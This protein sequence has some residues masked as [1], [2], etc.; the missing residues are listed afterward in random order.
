MILLAVVFT[1][2]YGVGELSV[3]FLR[4]F[5]AELLKRRDLWRKNSELREEQRRGIEKISAEIE[6]K[7]ALLEK[8]GEEYGEKKKAHELLTRAL[9]VPD[10]ETLSDYHP[11][12][13]GV[14]YFDRT[15]FREIIP[16]ENIFLRT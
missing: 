8:L 10:H 1:S 15:R 12:S 13:A 4:R 11:D 6:K 2:E 5:F 14:T 7:T 9:Q 16:L 3:S